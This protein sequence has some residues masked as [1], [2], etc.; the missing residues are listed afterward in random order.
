LRQLPGQNKLG[1]ALISLGW[2]ELTRGQLARSRVAYREGLAAAEASD[3]RMRMGRGVG[4]A[5]GLAAVGGAPALAARLF[6]AAAAQR[7]AEQV[8]LKPVVQAELDQ[9]TA[10]VRDAL[11]DAAF[12]SAWD[13]GRALPLEEALIEATAVL[14]DDWTAECLNATRRSPRAMAGGPQL[15][16]REWEVL[17]LLAAGQSDKEIAMALFISSRTASAH[18]SAIIGKLGVSSR[19]AAAVIAAR[20]LL[21]D[22]AIPPRG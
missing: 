16:R 11:G 18:V 13:A 14:A 19:A 6:G 10:G 15:T 9:L 21:L 20:D 3:D 17:R 1:D 7:D 22:S 5:A 4:G 12:S 8:Q 2:A